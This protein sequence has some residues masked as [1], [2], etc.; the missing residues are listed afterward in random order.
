MS[1]EQLVILRAVLDSIRDGIKEFRREHAES[2]ESVPT[3]PDDI[4]D[5]DR[6]LYDLGWMD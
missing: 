1:D 6:R 2:I 5:E 4:W 3:P